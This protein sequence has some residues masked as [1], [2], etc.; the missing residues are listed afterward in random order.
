M[1]P[2]RGIGLLHACANIECTEC[3][4]L[5]V[6]IIIMYYECHTDMYKFSH[7]VNFIK[8]PGLGMNNTELNN[9]RWLNSTINLMNCLLYYSP[10]HA[11]T[12]I[13]SC[14]HKLFLENDDTFPYSYKIAQPTYKVLLLTSSRH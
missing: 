5:Y 9:S 2:Y 6:N 8:F 11:Y 3:A 1:Y 12:V 13:S 10:T 4:V 14:F 7:Y